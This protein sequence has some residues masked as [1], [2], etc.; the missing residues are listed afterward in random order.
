LDNEKKKIGMSLIYDFVLGLLYTWCLFQAYLHYPKGNTPSI[1]IFIVVYVLFTF[2]VRTPMT[3][4]IMNSIY[5]LT[6]PLQH[7]YLVS[8][9]YNVPFSPLIELFITLFVAIIQ[10]LLSYVIIIFGQ[11]LLFKKYQYPISALIALIL[12]VVVTFFRSSL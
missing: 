8:I 11:K 10:A 5:L 9:G 7:S 1:S 3:V 4:V 6:L 2:L 12:S